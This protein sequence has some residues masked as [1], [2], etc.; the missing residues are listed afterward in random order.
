M[1]ES[2]TGVV[3]FCS[4]DDRCGCMGV[5]T[6]VLFTREGGGDLSSWPSWL[7]ATFASVSSKSAGSRSSTSTAV[8]CELR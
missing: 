4:L 3:V 6:V 8:K 2:I 7:D 1:D 5:K